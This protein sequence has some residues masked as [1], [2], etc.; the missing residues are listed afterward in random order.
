MLAQRVRTL[1]LHCCSSTQTLQ[2]RPHARIAGDKKATQGRGLAV[3]L[4]A[5][6]PVQPEFT[7]RGHNLL[8]LA[9]ESVQQLWC[10]ELAARTFSCTSLYFSTRW[11]LLQALGQGP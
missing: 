2:Q 8:G 9:Q 7:L 6:E 4:E 10:Q 11:G 5:G 3:R 1:S